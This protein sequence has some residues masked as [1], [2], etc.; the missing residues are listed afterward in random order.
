VVLPEV[1]DGLPVLEVE[2]AR[3]LKTLFR[4]LGLVSIVES[5]LESRGE[6]V[7]AHAVVTHLIPELRNLEEAAVVQSHNAAVVH[8]EWVSPECLLD[9]LAALSA[10]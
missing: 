4:R 5:F 3:L 9:Q 7:M 10:R 8:S 6:W 1:D 2:G